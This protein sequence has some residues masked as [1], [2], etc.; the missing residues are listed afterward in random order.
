MK[1]FKEFLR[2]ASMEALKKRVKE[3]KDVTPVGDLGFIYK[4]KKGT[5]TFWYKDADKP[6]PY[7][8]ETSE[9]AT[10]ALKNAHEQAMGGSTGE[11][12]NAFDDDF[13]GSQGKVYKPV[14]GAQEVEED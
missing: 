10:E 6:S 3:K 5:W 12:P 7:T 9:K 8:Y 13:M 1:S 2:E 11:L 4:A 14:V